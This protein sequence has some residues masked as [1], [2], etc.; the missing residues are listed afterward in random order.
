MSLP[1]HKKKMITG[2]YKSNKPPR[3]KNCDTFTFRPNYDLF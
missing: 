1:F 2:F 3:D